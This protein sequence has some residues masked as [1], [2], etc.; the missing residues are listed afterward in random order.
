MQLDKLQERLETEFHQD[1]NDTV[2]GLIYDLVGSVP[3]VGTCVSWNDLQ[4]EVL[5]L[6]GQ[7][8]LSVRVNLTQSPPN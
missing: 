3:E 8:I 1:E 7:R 5:G 6:D 2:G 4:F